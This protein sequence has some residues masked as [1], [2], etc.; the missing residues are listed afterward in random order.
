MKKAGALVLILGCILA[1]LSMFPVSPAKSTP[2]D[3][4]AAQ[5]L[6]DTGVQGGFIV[7]LSCGTGEL[8]A[9][10]GAN[11]SY[12]VHG[13]DP[14]SSNIDAARTHISS[15]GLYGRITAEVH[16]DTT[17]L[18]YIDNMVT[19]LVSEV[20]VDASPAEILR[21]LAPNGVAYINNGGWTMTTKPRPA[22]MDD[23][24]HYLHDASNNAV[25]NDTLVQ[26]P[27]RFQWIGG[28]RYSRHHDH[29][30]SISAYV[31]TED[32][33]FYIMDEGSRECIQLPP[34][35]SLFARDAFSGTILWKKPIDSWVTHMWPFK[36][37]PAQLPRRL[38]AVDDRVYATLGLDSTR[39]SMLDAATGDVLWFDPNT[40]MTEEIIYSEGV[41]FTMVKDNPSV[42][43]WNEYVPQFRA[44]GS[45][46]TYVANTFPWDEQNRRLRAIDAETGEMLWEVSVPIAPLTLGADPDGVYFH[47]GDS[48]VCLDRTDGSEIWASEPVVRQ[49][50]IPPKFG[51]TLVIYGDNII[52]LGGDSARTITGLS[53]E[54]G[55]VLWSDNHEKSGHNCPYDLLAIDGLAWAGAT[56]SSGANGIFIGWDPNSGVRTKEFLPDV[57]GFPSGE[58]PHWFHQR[59]YRSKGT[60]N[61]LLPSRNGIEF[62][63]FRNE[64]WTIHHWI[65]GECLYGVMPA[66][67]LI[68]TAATDCACYFESKTFG[69]TTMASAYPDPDYPQAPAD[70]DRLVTGPAYGSALGAATGA[71]D[72]PTYRH[73]ASRSGKSPTLVPADLLSTWETDLGPG[74]L[75]T[76]TVANG[77]IYVA[78]I[79]EHIVYALDEATGAI[80]WSFR[81][82]GRVDS[83]PTI[84][85]DRVIFGSADGYVY[86]LRASDGE[87]V[88]QFQGAPEDLH[89]QYFEQIESVWPVHGSVL[90]A[91]DEV[92]CI[93]GRNMF[94]DGGLRFLRLDPEFGTKIGEVVLDDKDPN[95]GENLQVHIKGLNMPVAMTDVLSYD[96]DYIYMHSARFDMA[97]KW[98]NI[99]PPAKPGGDQ[100]GEGM[101]LF[102]PTGFLDDNYMHRSYWVW[103]RSWASGAGGW[104]K[105]GDVTPAG[106]MIVVDDNKVYAYG[107][108]LQFYKWSS[109]LDH[110][111]YSAEKYPTSETVEYVWQDDT[112][113]IH[114][115]AMC[116][117]DKILFAAGVPDVIDEEYTFDNP[118]DPN[119]LVVFAEQDA[120]FNDERGGWLRAVLTSDGSTLAEYTLESLPVWDGMVAANGKLYLALR[121]GKVIRFVGGNYPPVIDTG[122]A[123]NIFPAAPDATLDATII[124]DG[125][126]LQDPGDP[127]SLPV[128]VTA[129]WIKVSGPGEVVFGDANSIDTTVSFSTW[130]DYT[131]RLNAT[132]SRASYYD[133][134]DLAVHRPGDLDYDNDI[135]EFDLELFAGWWTF[136]LCGEMINDWCGGANQSGSGFV[137]NDSFGI[138]SLNWLV[139][140]EPAAP[141]NFS[142]KGNLSDISLNWADNTEPDMPGGGYNVYRSDTSG[143]G[144]SKINGSLV[145]TSDYVDSTT[146]SFIPYYYVVTAVDMYGYESV[147]SVQKSASRGPQ[148]DVK[149]VAGLGITVDANDL[150]THLNDQGRNNDAVQDVWAKRPLYVSAGINGEPSIE[151]DGTGVHLDVADS[152]QINKTTHDA[153]TLL[154]VFRTSSDVTTR[155]MLWEQGGG[156]RGLNFYIAEG[157]LYINGWD[158]KSDPTWGPTFLNSSISGNTTYVATMIMNS[159]AGTFSGFINGSPIGV[160]NGIGDLPGH[161]DN[162]ALGHREGASKFHNGGNKVKA[163]FAGLIAEFHSFDA[164]LSEGD[165]LALEA[166][167]K[168]KYGIAP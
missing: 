79:H 11:E 121:N 22:E 21:V 168:D 102:S 4:L 162:C 55:E 146:S 35:W 134:L 115:Q 77:Q 17:H 154:V 29:M 131:L 46:K 158:G 57:V 113:P 53:K 36:S 117:A 132:D 40:V 106:R 91:N 107:R 133:D 124:D 90:V 105:A 1:G 13:L 96:G 15:K 97:G 142:A 60:V 71:E 99:A 41:L 144:Y 95:T 94:V 33:V 6:A 45:N 129:N 26:P 163:D 119:N 128:G 161:S 23:W 83:P 156:S 43:N 24:T 66:N 151:F 123:R 147:Y 2:E 122:P 37:G 78:K 28:P 84:Y 136:D 54:T 143:S 7:H 149:L 74:K 108:Q 14:D 32:R 50:A 9:A 126:P 34:R 69:F 110:H 157:N 138:I 61:Y 125:F 62:V 27:A 109:P 141:S 12:M 86:C 139:G 112:F 116:L 25:S 18:P 98:L 75:S 82:D 92:Y 81:A 10:L 93:A 153:K 72:W 111:L 88:W 48:V 152:D 127:C 137:G 103:G 19:L 104:H 87:L 56:A 70:V 68:Y 47:D 160:V 58:Q 155:Q 30:A 16:E 165:R 140:V 114:V 42:T 164:V 80:L 65:R 59:C 145:A 63:D 101:H 100:N 166:I 120:A 38:V 5:I 8:T 159:A 130:G 148:W 20:A 49:S 3:V 76:L 89:M 31:A 39:L 167:L 118:M 85:H 52:F 135:D 73:D 51:P 67:G 150:V 44:T 64:T